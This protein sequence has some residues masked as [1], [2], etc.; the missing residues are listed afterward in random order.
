MYVEVGTSTILQEVLGLAGERGLFAKV[1][2]PKGTVIGVYYGPLYTTKEINRM[3]KGGLAKYVLGSDQGY[4][5]DCVDETVSTLMRL[6]NSNWKLGLKPTVE[7]VDR[8]E[9]KDFL[10]KA[11]RD[12]A[13]G[14][15]LLVDYGDEYWV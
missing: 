8:V 3:Y 11:V 12:I 7:F 15:E 9:K 10:V 5:R 4:C 13:A 2:I 6:I 14:D 1:D